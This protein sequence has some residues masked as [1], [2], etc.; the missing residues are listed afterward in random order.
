MRSS[1]QPLTTGTRFI[2]ARAGNAGSARIHFAPASVHPRASGERHLP[3]WKK[4]QRF[5]SSP[6]ERG[7]RHHLV[8]VPDRYRFI[9]ARAGNAVMSTHALAPL[10]VHPRASGERRRCAMKPAMTVGS[11]PRERG[12]PGVNARHVL[13]GRFIPARAGNAG[14]PV[15]RYTPHYIHPRASGERRGPPTTSGSEDGSSPRE[16]GTRYPAILR[17]QD[18]R[19]IPARA[20][21]AQ[22]SPA[23]RAAIS[24]HPRA[25]GERTSI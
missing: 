18:Q 9:P 20:G 7:T 21:N 6:R 4:S 1:S 2:P 10:P 12:T 13:C 23:S 15:F 14:R 5:G 8:W 22:P 11:S 3:R 24:V 16:R 25:S 17:G 19:F